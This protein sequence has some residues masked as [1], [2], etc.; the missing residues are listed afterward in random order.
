MKQYWL[1]LEAK[2]D[3]MS[4]RE[5]AMAFGIAALLLIT[6]VNTLLLDPLLAKQ[7][8]LSN[9]VKQEQQ[10]IAAL[11]A[12]IQLRVKS[13]DHDPDA[14]ARERLR[15][16]KQQSAQMQGDLQ[17]MQKGLVS[18]D[19]MAALLEDLLKGNSRLRL[20]S[21]KTLPVTP[22]Y[23]PIPTN[24]KQ[25]DGKAT[26]GSAPQQA[27][28][29]GKQGGADIVYKHG[30]EIVVQGGYADLTGY[31]SQVEALP[32]QLFWANA[33]LNVDTYPKA[34]LTLTLFTLSL[35]KKWLNI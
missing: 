5:R 7:K 27:K 22:L 3:A 16:L 18:P 17:G 21:L 2:V 11:Q 13:H 26:A 29:E 35:D 23:E 32:W 9:K 34:N 31:L 4:L 33:K 20:V 6:L 10:Q 24:V 30:V 19:K 12:E 1:R 8:E 14:P 15:T 28:S 25:I